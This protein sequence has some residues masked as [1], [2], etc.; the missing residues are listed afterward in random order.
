MRVLGY[1]W[2]ALL[3]FASASCA[4]PSGSGELA[5]IDNPPPL[6]P[7]LPPPPPPLPPP[8]P[9]ELEPCGTNPE[10]GRPY[11]R[12]PDG[13]CPRAS[14]TL[15][16]DHDDDTSALPVFPC[17]PPRPSARYVL[18]R[19][20]LSRSRSLAGTERRLSAALQ[21]IGHAEHSFYRTCGGFALVTRLEQTAP[22]GALLPDVE[23]WRG[24]RSGSARFSL[25]GYLR[26][27]FTA[28]PGHYRLIV[29]KVTDRPVLTSG[30]TTTSTVGEAWLQG[31]SDRLDAALAEVPLTRAHALV[32]LVYEFRKPNRR[33]SAQQVTPGGPPSSAARR[34]L[35]SALGG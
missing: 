27:L 14:G 20:L 10:T 34:L 31:G 2:L 3:T 16:G 13:R 30:R 8:P 7:P 1:A 25:S 18:D 17:Q 19:N 15:N 33:A 26:L 6:P 28:Q 4:S 5:S 29:L 9:T 12:N 23:R 24:P 35:A 32:A 11:I 21:R 22:D